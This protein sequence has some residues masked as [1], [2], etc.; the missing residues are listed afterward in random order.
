MI[1]YCKY[2]TS[3]KQFLTLLY[4]QISGKDS[5]REIENG[6]LAN[7]KRLYHLGM[8]V[9]SESTLAEAMNRRSHEIF[10][11]LFE[12]LLDWAM[13]LARII[14][15]N[16]IILCMRSTVQPLIYAFRNMIG[17]IT[18]KTRVQ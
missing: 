15:S 2:F 10:R 3:W 18:A 5:L 11:K 16:S 6:L 17:S 12:E 8:E 4:T 1:I 14:S 9:V 7:Y 13:E